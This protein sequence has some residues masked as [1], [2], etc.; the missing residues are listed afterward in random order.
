MKSINAFYLYLFIK[1]ILGYAIQT[2]SNVFIQQILYKFTLNY[3]Y[4]ILVKTGKFSLN[5]VRF[6]S[7]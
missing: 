6:L 1:H 2:L 3:T 5:L 7:M 4:H